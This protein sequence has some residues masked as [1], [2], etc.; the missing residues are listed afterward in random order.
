MKR[1]GLSSRM[2][3]LLAAP[4]ADAEFI[5]K[6]MTDLQQ[7]TERYSK[8]IN[9]NAVGMGVLSL[10]FLLLAAHGVGEFTLFGVEITRYSALVIAIPP[11][12]AFLLLGMAMQGIHGSVA[13]DVYYELTKQ[14]YPAFAKASFDNLMMQ[15]N[16]P[17]V[18]VPSAAWHGSRL[19]RLLDR[20][21]TF[22]IVVIFLVPF[23]FFIYAFF[24]LF[25]QYHAGNAFV[26]LS[27]GVTALCWILAMA[28]ITGEAWEADTENQTDVS[29]STG[30]AKKTE[31]MP[32][33][34]REPPASSEPNP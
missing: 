13:R 26:W 19:W 12:I 22:M 20:L 1:S 7:Q 16:V 9:L 18:E 2:R 21:S 33:N 28:I 34:H 5:R 25:R 23:A 29:A 3:E 14:A 4:E 6:F 17:F 30:D 31:D 11:I 24:I 8:G 15:Y 32:N 10:F 27:L